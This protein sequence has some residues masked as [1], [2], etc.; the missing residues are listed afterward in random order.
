MCMLSV[1]S[2]HDKTAQSTINLMLYMEK[3]NIHWG[4]RPD[5]IQLIANACHDFSGFLAR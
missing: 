5:C 4:T 3:N 2:E 1:G